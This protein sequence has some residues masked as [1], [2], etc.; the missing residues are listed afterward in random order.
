MVELRVDEMTCG[1]C[2][3][4]VTQAVRSVEPEARV[5]VDL[6]SKRVRVEG[7]RSP[8]DLIRALDAAGY[9]AVRAGEEKPDAER[10]GGCC[11]CR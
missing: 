11:G 3:R 1:H 2:V 7:A 8:D 5:E 6:D 4:A 10:R 9:A